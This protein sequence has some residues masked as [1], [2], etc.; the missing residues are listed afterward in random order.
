MVGGSRGG[1]MTYRAL[2]LVNWIKAAVIWA[3]PTNEVR[4]PKFRK[5][6]REH[7][8]SLYGKAKKEQ[9]KRSALYW[10][11]KI[12]KKTP[13]LIMHG[14]GDWRVLAHDSIDMAAELYK[15]K[16][17]FR[18][19]IFEGA[20]H[21]MTELKKE[22]NEQMFNWLGRFLKNKEPLPNLKLHGR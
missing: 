6:W 19:I 16:V 9:V 18:L 2:S 22:F 13:I 15:H 4:V 7:Q 12:T 14:T 8:I 1:F 17:P 20:D 10:A 11:D 3:G 5:G 21:S